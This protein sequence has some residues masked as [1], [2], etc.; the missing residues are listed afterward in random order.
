ME[1]HHDEFLDWFID[2][3][4]RLRRALAAVGYG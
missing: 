1:E 2:A 3:G 4:V